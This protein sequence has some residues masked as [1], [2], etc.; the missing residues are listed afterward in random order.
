MMSVT[1]KLGAGFEASAP[2]P[3]FEM[4]G[5]V[6]CGFDRYSVAANGQKFLMIESGPQPQVAEAMHV[7]LHWDTMMGR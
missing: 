7:I 6:D 2:M 4:R 5:E 1:V 3:L